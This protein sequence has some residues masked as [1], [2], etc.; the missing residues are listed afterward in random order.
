MTRCARAFF[1]VFCA[2]S[3]FAQAE[4]EVA[5]VKPSGTEFRGTSTSDE[6]GYQ[7]RG[8]TLKM[9]VASAYGVPEFR[10]EGGPGWMDSA[11]WDIDARTNV[12]GR[13]TGSAIEAPLT[14]LLEQRFKLRVTKEMKEASVYFLDVAKSGV[15]M[16]LSANQD[17][18]SQMSFGNGMIS[19]PSVTTTLL[20]GTLTRLLGRAVVDRT[21][22]TAKYEAYFSWTP[23]AGEGDPT[24]T[25][26]P[27]EISEEQRSIF[28]ALEEELGLKLSSGKQAMPLVT[29][30]SAERPGEN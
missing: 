7:A 6:G 22:L 29:V 11:R 2:G 13:L 9:L 23:E 25:A 4:F 17:A 20:T 8:A 15:K 12:A 1:G 10:V 30:V 26:L 27:A 21:G 5:S 16:K 3:L 14:K 18:P 24:L 28:A 19:S